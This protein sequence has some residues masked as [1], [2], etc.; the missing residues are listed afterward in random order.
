MFAYLLMPFIVLFRVP[1]AVFC[2][3]WHPSNFLARF[4]GITLRRL[5]VAFFGRSVSLYPAYFHLKPSLH[6][7][8]L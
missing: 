7:L 2:L 6:E 4:Y 5:P 3:F 8:E 1:L